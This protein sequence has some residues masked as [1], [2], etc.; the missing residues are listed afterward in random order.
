MHTLST[1]GRDG[2]NP[3]VRAGGDALFC[4]WIEKADH[5]DNRA[6]WAGWLDL[7]GW[8][9]S[10]PR[11]L[12]PAGPTTW[13]LNAA[14]DDAGRAWVVFNATAGTRADELFLV[15]VE[16]ETV[17]LSRL[18]GDDGVASKY[19]DLAVGAAG[20]ALTWFDQ[21]DGNPEVYL[22][23]APIA[24]L[25]E[26]V[27]TR[28]ARV[29]VTQ[30]ESIGAYVAWN[31]RR[32]GL[33]WSDDSDGQHEVYFQTFDDAGTALGGSRRLTHSPTA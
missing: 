9:L 17:A 13:N 27:E 2:R 26:G 1:P 29:T 11:R 24:E 19:P 33:V 5:D 6:V 15:Q 14:L 28:A 22:H 12:A 31:D 23:V 30:G 10:P 18:T 8:P 25:R 21:R 4:A 3:F 16:D 7:D 20:A 32:V